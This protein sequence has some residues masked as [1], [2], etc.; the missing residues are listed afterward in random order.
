LKKLLAIGH[1]PL[2]RRRKNEYKAEAKAKAKTEEE[3]MKNEE[4]DGP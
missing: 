2:A 1:S 3:D 4:N